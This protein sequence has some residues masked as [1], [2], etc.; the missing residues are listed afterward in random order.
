MQKY[1]AEVEEI[2]KKKQRLLDSTANEIITWSESA[3]DAR[4]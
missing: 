3:D 1:K 4:E 2:I